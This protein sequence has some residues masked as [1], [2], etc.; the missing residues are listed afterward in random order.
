MDSAFEGG[1]GRL[2]VLLRV[3]P[4]AAFGVG[5]LGVLL[6]VPDEKRAALSRC[7]P[8]PNPRPEPRP[9]RRWEPPPPLSASMLNA[10]DRFR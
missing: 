4:D 10:R 9:G 2:G 7:K 1:V 5:R 8:R 3:L 6:L